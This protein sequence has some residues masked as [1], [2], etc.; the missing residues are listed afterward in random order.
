MLTVSLILT[1]YNCLNHLITTLASIAM[2]DY[3]YIEIVI[4]DGSSTDGTLEY[5]REF[6]ATSSL[7]VIWTSEKDRGIYDAMNKGY[8]LSHGDILC[9][10]NDKFY[11]KDAVSLLV[12]AISNNPDC[13]GGHAD[14]VYMDDSKIKRR[15]RMGNGTIA[16]GW[17]PGHPTLFLKRSIFERYGLYDTSYT[18]SADYEF[19]VRILKDNSNKLIYVPETIVS[20]YYGGTS[21]GG[22]KNYIVSLCEAHRALTANNIKFPYFVDFLRIIKFFKQ[23]LV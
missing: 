4:K 16:K 12:N 15:W 8:L 18:C 1:T 9:F 22:L 6:A 17:M 11:R 13:I 3:P 21:T 10:F 5:I 7:D 23:F 19:M 14:L 2:Q 20:M